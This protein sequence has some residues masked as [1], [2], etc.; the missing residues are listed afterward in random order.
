MEIN[1][2][3]MKLIG[4]IVLLLLFLLLEGI[5][6]PFQAVFGIPCPGCNMTTSLFYLLHGNIEAS[7]FYHALLIPTMIFAILVLWRHLKKDVKGRNCLVWIWVGCMFVYYLYR[8]IF[9]FP[10]VPMVFDETSVLAHI[11]SMMAW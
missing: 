10:D 8:M 5:H 2:K 1:K 3:S 6:C 4:A 11:L 7:L 9:I